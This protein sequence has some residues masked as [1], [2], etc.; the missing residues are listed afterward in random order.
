MVVVEQKSK[1]K[2]KNLPN[3]AMCEGLVLC[4]DGSKKHKVMKRNVRLTLL[5]GGGGKDFSACI[6]SCRAQL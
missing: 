2:K 5:E 4:C 3:A 6:T 1:T